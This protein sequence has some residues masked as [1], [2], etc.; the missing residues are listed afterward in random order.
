[1]NPAE[2]LL[3]IEA[4]DARDT[5]DVLRK[6]LAKFLG[7]MPEDERGEFILGLFGGA[8]NDKVASMVHL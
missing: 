2:L 1:M 5:A 7:S 6:A 8:E 3:A 4:L